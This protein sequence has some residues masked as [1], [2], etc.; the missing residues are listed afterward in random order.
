[1]AA[2]GAGKGGELRYNIVAVVLIIIIIIITIINTNVSVSH[3][4]A[5]TLQLLYA[6]RHNVPLPAFRRNSSLHASRLISGLSVSVPGDITAVA[7]TQL[8]FRSLF[9]FPLP[10]A[11]PLLLHNQLQP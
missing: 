3:P 6:T 7:L 4:L 9:A 2:S 1:L 11:I 5:S 8:P 10:I